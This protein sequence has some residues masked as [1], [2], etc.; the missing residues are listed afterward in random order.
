MASDRPAPRLIFVNRFFFPDHSATAQILGDVAFDLAARG[1][2]VEVI[3]SR[4]LY[5]DAAKRL[6]P[7][8]TIREVV[9]HRVWTSRFGRATLAG[10]TLDYLTF[11]PF[12]FA[13]LIA[14]ARAGDVIVA[15][16]DPPLISVVAAGAAILRRAVLINWLQDLYPEVARA[17]GMRIAR[18]P[19]G[20]VL[21][22]LR[23]W[24]LRRAR[25]NVAVGE[26]MADR[27][28]AQGIARARIAVIQNW[29]DDG[30][31]VPVAPAENPL[32]REWG[33]GEDETIVGYSGNL[34]RAHEVE[35]LLGA[36][37]LLA[38]R[39]DIR[40]LFVGGGALHDDLRARAAETGVTS[41]IFRPYQPRERLAQSL[42]AAD[43]HWLSLLPAFEGLIVPSK[44][45]GIAAAGRPVIAVA[46]PAGEAGRILAA[47]GAGR[48]VPPG[49]AEGLANLV[50][51][52]ADDPA[53][54][55]RMG[56]AARAMS[57]GVYGKTAALD[58]WHLLLSQAAGG[59]GP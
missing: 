28:A 58:R 57:V 59:R 30:A 55:A 38:D 44:L 20:A 5:G 54:R 36:A 34:G 53:N 22:S 32:R 43:I 40:F 24:S 37:R 27:V 33:I 45:F 23:N 6:P 3:T 29:S 51:V 39:K 31:V 19:A 25:A 41:L 35:T 21:R 7:R 13:A 11:Y 9:V 15:K 49:D 47:S 2:R 4:G 10:R 1:W 56:A 12:A 50:R 8:E 46:D 48:A 18:G 52:L 16:T 14:R 42:G 17:F 26:L